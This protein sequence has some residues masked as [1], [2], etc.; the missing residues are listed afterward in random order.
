M[1]L[2]E[3]ASPPSPCIAYQSLTEH[4]FP[5][6]KR[7]LALVQARTAPRNFRSSIV[8]HHAHL[9]VPQPSQPVP[10]TLNNRLKWLGCPPSGGERGAKDT[11]PP[12]LFDSYRRYSSSLWRFLGLFAWNHRFSAHSTHHWP[13]RVPSSPRR[14]VFLWKEDTSCFATL[15][16][17]ACHASHSA[18]CYYAMI[19]S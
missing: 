4:N 10:S 17:L 12:V 9:T 11:G 14:S 2:I 7:V 6:R 16:T 3:I 1:R 19:L 5:P 15:P 18:L 13:P 8:L